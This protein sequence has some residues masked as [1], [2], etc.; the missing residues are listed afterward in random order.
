MGNAGQNRAR[1]LNENRVNV[2]G[3]IGRE[4]VEV[5]KLRGAG[6]FGRLAMGRILAGPGAGMWEVP[7][8]KQRNAGFYWCESLFRLRTRCPPRT[9]SRS[10]ESSL[11]CAAGEAGA[12]AFLDVFCRLR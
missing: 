3:S 2:C 7:G 12:G 9:G 1:D 11:S 8:Q 6:R 10:T 4:A 5:I